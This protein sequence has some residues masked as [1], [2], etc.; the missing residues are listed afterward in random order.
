MFKLN[1]FGRRNFTAGE[2][3][4][5]MSVDAQKC[6]DIFVFL[7]LLWSGPFQIIVSFVALYLLMGW[8]VIA[9]FVFLL[10]LLPLNIFISNREKKYHSKQMKIKDDRS[11]LMNEILAGIKIIKMYAWEDSF[12]AKVTGY[13][14]KELKQL[15][16][17]KLLLANTGFT[18]SCAPFLVSIVTFAAY[19][20]L[21]GN[22]LTAEKAFV[23]ISL[24]NIMRFP[25][26]ILPNI[27]SSIVAYR[28]SVKRITKFLK[29]EELDEN[30][31]K[32]IL[33]TDD[34]ESAVKITNGNFSW[35]HEKPLLREINL[36]VLK[37]NFVAVVG[38]VGTGKSSLLSA[39]LGEIHKVTGGVRICGK[40][41]YVTQQPWIQ[42]ETVRDNII[43]TKKFKAEKYN[44][45]V[46]AC[47]LRADLDLLQMGDMTEIG[48]KGINLSGGQKQRVAL[49]RAVYNNADIYLLDDP[50]SAVDAHVGRYIFDNVIGP[51]GLLKNKVFINY[52][53]VIFVIVSLCDL[54]SYVCQVMIQ[55]HFVLKHR[56]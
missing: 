39:M 1:S 3:V 35:D 20:Y 13:R 34:S 33:E 24:F 15:R 41:A 4:N 26:F 19:I 10:F 17:S 30:D 37:G 8:S 42:N 6:H 2:M 50:L 47:S 11:K 14:N 27:V 31:V 22:V 46:D 40:V 51:K 43:F 21:A 12:L 49:A 45:I 18:I 54:V 36:D 32:R 28:I 48:E 53:I 5:L 9:G 56:K 29:G 38:K 25:L 52:V 44:S 16:N 23:S 55:I 7:P